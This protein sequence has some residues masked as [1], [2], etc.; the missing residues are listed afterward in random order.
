MGAALDLRREYVEYL[1]RFD[2][3]HGEVE[4]GKF[5]K[6][7]GRLVRKRRFEEFE[8]LFR[9]YAE[10]AKTYFDSLERGDTINDVAVKLLR[11]HATE[12]LL[13]APV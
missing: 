13:K 1:A 4:F 7:G 3:A 6:H 5:V 12:L 11:E 2:S 10:V 9:E 8:P